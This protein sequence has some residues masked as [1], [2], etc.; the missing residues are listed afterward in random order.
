LAGVVKIMHTI[1]TI[2]N[3]VTHSDDAAVHPIVGDSRILLYCYETALKTLSVV[4]SAGC[5][6]DSDMELLL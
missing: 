3:S 2:A 4:S 6:F 5:T 1:T